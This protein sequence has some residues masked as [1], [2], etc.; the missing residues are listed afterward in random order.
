M[1][2]CWRAA[3]PFSRQLLSSL[4]VRRP[5]YNLVLSYN[6]N[7]PDV[8]TGI[9]CVSREVAMKKILS[10][11]AMGS[12]CRQQ[13]VFH[14]ENSWKWLGEAER[15]EHLATLKSH[16]TSKNATPLVQ[17][18]EP[19]RVHQRT[20]RR[21]PPH[22]YSHASGSCTGTFDHLGSSVSCI[23]STG[24]FAQNQFV[25]RSNEIRSPKAFTERSLGGRGWAVFLCLALRAA[26]LLMAVPVRVPEASQE[27]EFGLVQIFR[28]R[29]ASAN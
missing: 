12:L 3:S 6:R 17:V 9:R 10:Y 29:M 1:S 2:S 24:H 14:P 23:V 21:L 8:M 7:T 13:A 22:E 4:V 28:L 19:N 27:S 26:T 15:W 18:T 20:R 11:R 5:Y 16:P 25:A